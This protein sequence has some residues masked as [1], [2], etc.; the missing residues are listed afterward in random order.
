MRE[1]L[2]LK[3][4]KTITDY[5][6]YH[7]KRKRL[8]YH[9]DRMIFELKVKN[10]EIYVLDTFIVPV[11]LNKRRSGKKIAQGTFDAE[12]VFDSLKGTA[13]GYIVVLIN[14][15]NLSLV[16][17]KI[18]SKKTSKVE[19]WDEMVISNLGTLNGKIKAVIADAG[20]SCYKVYE[21]SMS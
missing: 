21:M 17:V 7:K 4:L 16:D 10:G 5:A 12:F 14:L 13:V 19:I 11:D 6:E 8:S 2:D 20:F 3:V 15:Y 9:I 18:F 1:I